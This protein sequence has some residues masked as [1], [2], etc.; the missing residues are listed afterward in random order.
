MLN[1]TM[2]ATFCH[3][4]IF[5]VWWFGTFFV[6]YSPRSALAG[7]DRGIAIHAVGQSDRHDDEAI[8]KFG[9]KPIGA[10]ES[11]ASAIIFFAFPSRHVASAAFQVSPRHT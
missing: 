5:I 3:F 2:V 10:V 4:L 8:P 6:Q 7:R 11:F 9:N 1:N